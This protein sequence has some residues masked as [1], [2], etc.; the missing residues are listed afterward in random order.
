MNEG[1]GM[2]KETKMKAFQNEGQKEPGP[3]T[4]KDSKMTY[5]RRRR[6]ANQEPGQETSK[7]SKTT[8]V[9]RM[10]VN[11]LKYSPQGN[12]KIFSGST[13]ELV[14]NKLENLVIFGNSLEWGTH[15]TTL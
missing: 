14:I 13:L 4:T 10:Q 9:G 11:F 12:K 8:Y 2:S 3:E 7:Y 5:Y 6:V 1:L 15:V